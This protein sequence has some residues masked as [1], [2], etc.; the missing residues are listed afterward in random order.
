MASSKL[1]P[2]TA[3]FLMDQHNRERVSQ[4]LEQFRDVRLGGACPDNVII[5][6]VRG[7]R[8]AGAKSWSVIALNVIEAN[9]YK[10]RYACFREI[11]NTLNESVYH[12]IETTVERL[13]YPGWQFL[14][15]S[16][17]SPK[18]SI[19]VFRGL[20]D[21]TA[22]QNV[23]GMEGF[24]R[25]IVEEAAPLSGESIDIMLPTLFRTEGAKLW[26][27]YNQIL[28]TDPISI[29]VWNPFR[30]EPYARMIECAPGR[31]DN[32]WWNAQMEAL[33]LKLKSIDPDLWDHVYGGNPMTQLFNAAISRV[34]V[35][36]AMDRVIDNPEG[37][38]SV[39]V[40]PADMGDDK[41]Q[42]Y[43]RKGCKIIDHRE[44]RKMDGEYIANEV[45]HMIH[46]NPSIPIKLDTTGI[47]TSARDNLKRLGAKV[48]PINFG[49]AS[50]KPDEY[51]DIISEMWFSFN[52]ILPMLDI[53]DDAELMSDLSSRL[54]KYE[55]SKNRRCIE[56]KK[57][58]KKRFLRSPDKGDAILLCFYEGKN[59]IISDERKAQLRD[60]WRR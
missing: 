59:I 5:K 4:K 15:D 14:N 54:Y 32:P 57:E 30:D 38:V 37:G 56:S 39:G 47:G 3:L 40:D 28:E 48:I 23:K 1:D 20:K 19:F 8:G 9:Y 11:Q 35:R 53:P 10:E 22:T 2:N 18:G 33:S 45:W 24:T 31:I 36:Q 21:M 25:F 29:K 6:G 27:V 55:T 41:T 12:L 17:V 13:R 46:R 49:E 50:T 44:L 16:I 58:F 7:G 26:F 43:V 52:D 42:I 34:L 60:R 51:P